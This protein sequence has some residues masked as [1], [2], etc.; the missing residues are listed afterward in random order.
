MKKRFRL[1][2][3]ATAFSLTLVAVVLVVLLLQSRSGGLARAQ[4][5]PPAPLPSNS[6]PAQASVEL[7]PSQLNAIQLEPVGTDLF[8]V[9][10]TAVGSIDYDQD[11][12]VQVFSPYP[13]KILHALVNLGDAVDKGQPLYTIASP[14]L[15][16][17]E[18]SLVAAAA[19]FA[20]T[21]KELARVQ[22]LAGADG[23]SQ[24]ELEQANS[25]HQTAEGALEAARDAVRLF[26]KT[27]AEI[28][29]IIASRKIDPVLVVPSPVNGRITARNAQ[30]G[31]LVQP[32]NSPAPYAVAN[33]STKWMVAQVSE[34]DS[35]A[36]AVG[37]S[38]QAQVLA[39]PGRV[40]NGQISR[41]G[42]AVDPNTHRLMVRC[43]IADPRDELRPG[44]L[45]SFVIRVKE[46]VQSVALP[47]AGVVRNGDGSMAAWV[48][49][50]RRHFAQ[51]LIQVGLQREGRWQVLSGLR[52][53]E[54]AVTQGA[55]FLSNMLEAPPTD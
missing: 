14:D 32:G 7:E 46:P 1:L 47:M 10:E 45:A 55:V 4:S 9:E 19:N 18:S 51:R 12:A 54:L 36:L 25:D 43:E 37:Q 3:K 35:P 27:A 20:L 15:L 41:L 28:D 23:L 24:R 31:L 30:P 50:D 17:A 26:G 6:P 44:M 21:G 11:L 2:R 8:P 33:L 48:T 40:F 16:A 42:T 29:R 38:V 39:Y 13:G 5:P 34:S 52:R 53:G 49:T 22:A